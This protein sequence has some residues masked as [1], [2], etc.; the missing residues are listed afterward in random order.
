MYKRLS[1]ILFMIATYSGSLLAQGSGTEHL[2]L[3]ISE[4]ISHFTKKNFQIGPPQT[5]TPIDSSMQLHSGN[6][7]EFRFNFLAKG[8]F[9]SE[10][11]Y[12]IESTS[13][14]F[15]RSTPP[16]ET[17]SIPVQIHNFGIN[18]LYYPISTETAK[19]RP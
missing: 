12:G 16:A 4:S 15:N 5:A 17:L 8:C 3:S 19:W 2:E 6:R 9:G 13:V 18:L 1:A 11:L 10:A 14:D 7:H